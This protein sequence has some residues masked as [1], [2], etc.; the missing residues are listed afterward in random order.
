MLTFLLKRLHWER[1]RHFENIFGRQWMDQ[2]YV[3]TSF[4]FQLALK[5]F[6]KPGSVNK[7]LASQTFV[8]LI[9][10]SKKINND[11]ELTQSDPISY[12]Q[13]QKGNN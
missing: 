11:Q 1:Q 12:P 4:L 3:P 6:N 2:R 9:M 5:L 8:A 7:V 10:H 13:N